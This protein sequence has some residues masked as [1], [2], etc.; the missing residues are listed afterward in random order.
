MSGT[1]FLEAPKFLLNPKERDIGEYFFKV[2]VVER[3]TYEH[4]TL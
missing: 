2:E 3:Y 1:S 4:Y